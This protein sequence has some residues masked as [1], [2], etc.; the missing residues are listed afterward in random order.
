MISCSCGRSSAA[1]CLTCDSELCDEHALGPRQGRP[2]MSGDETFLAVP[3]SD[4]DAWGRPTALQVV[5]AYLEGWKQSAGVSCGTC[6]QKNASAA[7]KEMAPA[8]GGSAASAVEKSVWRWIHE[9][10]PKA[11]ASQRHSWEDGG[12]RVGVGIHKSYGLETSIEADQRLVAS[13]PTDQLVRML[14][15][16]P[17]A[18]VRIEQERTVSCQVTYIEGLSLGAVGPPDGY[19]TFATVV[20]DPST[21]HFS[22]SPVLHL[23]PR[24]E[25]LNRRGRK[26]RS[27]MVQGRR[28]R[29]E[30]RVWTPDV[31]SLLQ[32]TPTAQAIVKNHMG[33]VQA[34]GYSGWDEDAYH[35][36]TRW[37][38]ATG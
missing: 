36:W 9:Y 38:D 33:R 23:A 32:A 26:R 12:V 19:G 10:R 6:R 30:R 21:G 4:E 22:Y 20:T 29:A 27:P 18:G 35:L 34:A 31:H 14:S 25:V 16:G 1:R 2:Y 24:V 28:C 8:H 15:H 11:W 17:G 5:S 3:E 13:V 37:V 7:I